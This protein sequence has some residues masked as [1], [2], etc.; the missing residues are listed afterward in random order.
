MKIPFNRLSSGGI[1][2]RLSDA[3]KELSAKSSDVLGE[4]QP[5]PSNDFTLRKIF[6]IFLSSSLI[7]HFSSV[8]K[9][10]TYLC[11]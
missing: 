10:E 2:R 5:K 9:R 6:E 7:S 11:R 4:L 1:P 8:G 3:S